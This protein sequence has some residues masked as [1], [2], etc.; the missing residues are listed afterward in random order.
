MG[1]GGYALNVRRALNGLN[2]A[3]LRDLPEGDVE[4]NAQ[5]ADATFCPLADSVVLPG[6]RAYFAMIPLG[7]WVESGEVVEEGGV[8]RRVLKSSGGE[9]S[10]VTEEDR[11]VL[12]D[13]GFLR[14]SLQQR[15]S[16]FGGG[17]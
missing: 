7:P 3:A 11:R 13:V 6:T 8:L 15:E 9:E 17:L 4:A 5:L 14:G 1:V 12:A 10:Y 16:E 2:V